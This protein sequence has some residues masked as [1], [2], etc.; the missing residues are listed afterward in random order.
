ML[1]LQSTITVYFSWTWVENTRHIILSTLM[2]VTRTQSSNWTKIWKYV[3]PVRPKALVRKEKGK[4]KKGNCK[5][6]YATRKAMIQD[7]LQS[8]KFS[9]TST[10][11]R[12]QKLATVTSNYANKILWQLWKYATNFSRYFWSKIIE[13]NIVIKFRKLELVEVPDLTVNKQL[14]I[15]GLNLLRKGVSFPK[16]KIWALPIFEQFNKL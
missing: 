13:M 8:W 1:S 15:F 14:W 6:F 4:K 10:N 3:L 16:E 9:G 7:T 12:K 5:A 11:L 2:L